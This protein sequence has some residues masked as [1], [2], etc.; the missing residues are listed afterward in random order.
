MASVIHR[1][2]GAVFDMTYGT[3]QEAS[4]DSLHGDYIGGSSFKGSIQLQK[5]FEEF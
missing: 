1:S 4:S 2:P 5:A 3:N